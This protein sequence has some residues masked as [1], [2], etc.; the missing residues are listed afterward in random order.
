MPGR[1]SCPPSRILHLYQ[2]CPNLAPTDNY[3][4]NLLIG[5]MSSN[6]GFS[7]F[8]FLKFNIYYKKAY[9][10]ARDLYWQNQAKASGLP[11]VYR[12]SRHEFGVPDWNSGLP[13]RGASGNYLIYGVIT[14]SVGDVQ[15]FNGGVLN[16]KDA[17]TNVLQDTDT[18]D[19]Y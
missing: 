17:A 12:G 8:R 7:V 18:G 2:N 13:S 14:S 1:G 10:C 9:V 4:S 11:S 19:W 15:L 6:Y 16:A 3:S 5:I